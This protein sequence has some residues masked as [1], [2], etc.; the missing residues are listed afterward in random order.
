[1]EETP[2]EMAMY[3]KMCAYMKKKFPK[4]APYMDDEEERSFGAG[5]EAMRERETQYQATIA[6]ERQ[7]TAAEKTARE[8]AEKKLATE[9]AERL[10]DGVKDSVK[11][12]R[13]KELKTLTSMPEV[14]RPSHV[15]YMKDNYE[16]LVTSTTT[17]RIAGGTVPNTDANAPKKMT[18][19][20]YRAAVA[21][22]ET[23][24]KQW[25]EAHAWAIS[26]VA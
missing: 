1:M 9:H 25:A 11:F 18:E 12:N 19:A 16:K 24:K 21:Y 10:L 23:N 2:E 4:L 3:A 13:E 15:Q 6:R 5:E 20:Q 14:D 22:M 17:V 7:A 8:T 26:N